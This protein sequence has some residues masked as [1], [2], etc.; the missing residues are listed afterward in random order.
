MRVRLA[1]ARTLTGQW[2]IETMITVRANPV[3]QGRLCHSLVALR[4][5][6]SQCLSQVRPARTI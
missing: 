6:N 1:I 2:I 5:S 4:L 3:Y